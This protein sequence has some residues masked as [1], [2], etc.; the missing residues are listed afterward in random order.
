[1]LL[2][3][4]ST[5]KALANTTE[6]VLRALNKALFYQDV[7]VCMCMFAGFAYH[8]SFPHFRFL[9]LCRDEMLI[10]RRHARFIRQSCPFSSHLHK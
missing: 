7:C 1:M 9:Q 8:F 6:L 5:Q 2:K 4:F 10:N 3:G